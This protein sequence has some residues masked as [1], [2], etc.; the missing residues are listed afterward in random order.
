MTSVCVVVVTDNKCMYS[1]SYWWQVYVL[2]YVL[3]T[4]LCVVIVTDDKCGR[5]MHPA[6]VTEPW[7]GI[8]E[9]EDNSK[10]T[11]VH[12]I[13][14]PTSI[15]WHGK[16]RWLPLHDNE[17]WLLVA[18]WLRLL[19]TVKW[20]G[21]NSRHFR[22]HDAKRGNSQTMSERKMWWGNSFCTSSGLGAKNGK[23]AHTVVNCK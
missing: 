4:S 5:V 16:E 9:K 6:N 21:D 22:A 8:K 12:D 11:S 7:W 20:T 14:G 18:S 23:A 13:K 2:L 3:M 10:H 1:C 19:Q 15:S 17:T